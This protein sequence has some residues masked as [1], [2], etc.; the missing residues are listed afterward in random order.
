MHEQRTDVDAN[1][2]ATAATDVEADVVVV[3]GG[4][5]G[6]AAAV[7]A[8][9]EGARTL[10]LES[11]GSV[12]G[13]LAWQL[14]EHSAGFHDV[15][16]NQVV[17]GFGQRLVDRLVRGGGSPGHVRDDVG[18]TATRTPVDH[19]ELALTESIMLAEAGVEVWLQSGPHAI[20]RA[21]DV[22]EF[23]AV[24]TPNGPRR[25]RAP[26][27]IDASG[28][29]VVAS[30]AGVPMQPDTADTQP[31]SLLF[32][33]G[34]V[35]VGALLDYLR[36]HPSEVR[37]GSTLGYGT[38]EHAN[39][40]GLG[41][42]LSAGTQAESSVCAAPSCIWPHGRS[43]ARW[44]STPPAPRSGPATDGRARLTRS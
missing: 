33:L 13:T 27:I 25:V 44:S 38:D 18:Y 42:L 40:W 15:R 22:I 19:A 35:D 9:E 32:K 31:A 30:L 6:I 37:P 39:V 17:G 28:D 8:S 43:A 3:G 1:I 5:A 2:D 10:L 26:V 4:S 24:H 29:A 16:G 7:S 34:G 20:H 41:E 23:L 11:S 12:G 36:E 14:L 21:G